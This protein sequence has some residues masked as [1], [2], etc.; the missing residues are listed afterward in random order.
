MSWEEI[1]KSDFEERKRKILQEP[2]PDNIFTDIYGKLIH[3]F[4]PGNTA[5]HFMMRELM[6][7]EKAFE[8]IENKEEWNKQADRFA[9]FLMTSLNN[10]FDAFESRQT[11]KEWLEEKD[12]YME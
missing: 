1:L 10:I 9:L 2:G 11:A 6:R 4:E 7:N 3:R 8:V 12:F 5:R